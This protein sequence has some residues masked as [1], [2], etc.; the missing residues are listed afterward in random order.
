[1]NIRKSAIS[2]TIHFGVVAN[3]VGTSA[4][5]FISVFGTNLEP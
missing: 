4:G 1:M 2:S 3:I 5:N